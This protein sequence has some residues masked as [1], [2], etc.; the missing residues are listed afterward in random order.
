M[1]T[2]RLLLQFVKFRF[3]AQIE[4]P[5][6]YIAGILG[7]WL[8]YGIEL[9]MIFLMVWNFGTLAGWTP[10][11]V[12]FLFSVWLMTYALG[13][14]FTYNI[15]RNFDQ[16]V[17]N[18][19]MDEALTR[20]VSPFAYLIFTHINLG[21]ISHISLTAVALGISIVQLNLIWSAWQWLWLIVLI[22]AGSVITGCIM[23]LCEMPAMHTR[24]RSPFG[25]LFWE[26][27]MFT[28]FPISIYPQSMQIVFTT[29]LPLGFINFYPVQVLLGKQDGLWVP[30]T[31]WIS[32]LVAA[33]FVG[34]TAFCWRRMSRHYESAG[35]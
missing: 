28:R 8:V 19:T 15:C 3:Y 34:I 25:M 22:L 32:P 17:I 24:S 27:R 5:G 2:T 35:T 29:I 9:F 4:Y 18:G 11:E 26:T 10:E 7:Q 31:I 6:A 16:L 33:L 20:P 30:Y 13:A 12:I 23:L 21:Y 1:H 14:T